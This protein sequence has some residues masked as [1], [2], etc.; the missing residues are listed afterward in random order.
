VA[1]LARSGGARAAAQHAACAR[2]AMARG[3]GRARRGGCAVF[4][5]QFW[6]TLCAAAPSRFLVAGVQRGLWRRRT[7]R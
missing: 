3:G 4:A 1:A 5:G 6:A 2:S 7:E